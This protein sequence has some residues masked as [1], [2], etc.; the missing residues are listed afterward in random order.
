MKL[1]LAPDKVK[2]LVE[3]DMRHLWHPFTQ[4]KQWVE[5]P[6]LIIAYGEGPYLI[7]IHGNR[8]LDGISSL[9][10]NLHGHRRKEIDDAVKEQID[11]ISHSTLLGLANI[12]SIELAE[13]LTRI[14]PKGLQYVFYSDNGSTAVEVGLKIAF[15]Y[16]QQAPEGGRSKTRFVSFWNSY[17]G[18]TLG[19][20]STG[21]IDTFHSLYRPLLFETFKVH[22]PYCYR[23]HLKRTYPECSMACVA[24]LQDL[25]SHHAHEIAGL[26]IEPLVQG[27]GG[28]LTA[29]P[30]FLKAVAGLCRSHDVLLIADEVAVGFGRT[31][32]MFACEHEDVQPDL[33]AV[34]KGITGGYLPLAATLATDR[35]FKAFLAEY[36]EMKTFF[37]GHSYTGNPLACAAALASLAV[38][39]RDSTLEH[40]G[41]KI[42]H[43][44]KRLEAFRDLP[45]VGDV[46]QQGFIA[47]IE[48]VEDKPSRGPYPVAARIGHKVI[49]EARHHGLILRPLGDVIV[50]M[51]PLII[52]LEELDRLLDIAYLSIT[53][54]TGL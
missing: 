28:I 38:F 40:L 49:M 19:A 16:W 4:M 14:A 29:P 22:Y 31:G 21:G 51:P 46:R 33:L 30:G 2:A 18:D 48:L 35:I 23:C 11:R 50:I 1:P 24:E 7:D 6:P 42:L 3:A 44:G 5:Q 26:V 13:E 37:H 52:S 45:H 10:V 36:A 54:I 8:Y 17:H 12:P 15:Q 47:G 41:P 20:V 25:L 53:H 39:E 43:L 9:W 34:A 32:R 27:A